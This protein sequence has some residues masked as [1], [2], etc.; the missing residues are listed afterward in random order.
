MLMHLR[1]QPGFSLDDDADDDDDDDDDAD[2]DH[3]DVD[4]D[5]YTNI[6]CNQ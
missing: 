1:I 5:E 3:D 6:M 4:D 2:N